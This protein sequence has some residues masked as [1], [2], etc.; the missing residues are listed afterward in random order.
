MFRSWMNLQFWTKLWMNRSTTHSQRQT[1]AATNWCKNIFWPIWTILYKILPFII[2]VF[3][4]KLYFSLH[5]LMKDIHL[6]IFTCK[7]SEKRKMQTRLKWIEFQ[8]QRVRRQISKS[9][10]RLTTYVWREKKTAKETQPTIGLQLRESLFT[11]NEFY[12]TSSNHS[13]TSLER[14]PREMGESLV[15]VFV[16]VFY[17]SLFNSSSCTA[18]NCQYSFTKIWLLSLKVIILHVTCTIGIF[19]YCHLQ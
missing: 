8:I 4:E 5:C 1:F 10:S 6:S 2:R 15:C 7:F 14:K 3:T 17:L 9:A 13:Q 12:Y 18:S 19:G 16:F 11:E